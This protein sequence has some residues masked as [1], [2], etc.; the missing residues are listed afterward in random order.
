[1]LPIV[2]FQTADKRIL[3]LSHC[4]WSLNTVFT[5]L[6]LQLAREKEAVFTLLDERSL[7]DKTKTLLE[8]RFAHARAAAPLKPSKRMCSVPCLISPYSLH[9]TQ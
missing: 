4:V 2:P 6:A 8:A 9:V 5:L 3:F 7:P 1:V